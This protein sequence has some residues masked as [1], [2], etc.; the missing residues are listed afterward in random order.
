[1]VS[2]VPNAIRRRL[3]QGDVALGAVVQMA[4]PEAVEMLGLAGYDFA[5]IDTEHGTIDSALLVHM[6]RAADAVGVA[7]IVRV[8]DHSSSHILRVLDAGAAGIL[9]PHV[10]TP[11][12]AMA[13]V[14][15]VKFAPEGER[16]ACPST[17]ATGHLTRDWPSFV[18]QANR[19][20]LVWCLIEDRE[21]LDAIDAIAA[22]P[23][24][25]GLM[26]GPFDLA[27]ALGLPGQIGHPEVNTLRD[28]V[29]KAANA[30]GVELISLSVWEPG[31]MAGART[32]GARVVIEGSDR[33]LLSTGFR[34]VFDELSSVFRK[35]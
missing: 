3:A 31:G 34:R 29:L 27:Q 28:K 25:D 9:A 12:D 4:S 22:V 11:G 30:R 6:I 18:Q 13:L 17:R 2:Q 15:S 21:A 7:S 20:T 33:A 23:G 14:R 32:R 8:P 26:F 35:P 1:M 19:D 16:G 5:V 24:V 10:R